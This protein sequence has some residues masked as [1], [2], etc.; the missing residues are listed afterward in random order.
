MTKTLLFQY[1]I[2]QD[3]NC[4]RLHSK[5]SMSSL[6]YIL[7]S[8]SFM[9]EPPLYFLNLVFPTQILSLCHSSYLKWQI[10]LIL[11]TLCPRPGIDW[12]LPQHLSGFAPALP[13]S[14]WTTPR[15]DCS[16][17]EP[18]APVSTLLNSHGFFSYSSPGPSQW[19]PGL[20]SVQAHCGHWLGTKCLQI[21]N[22][23]LRLHV[24]SSHGFRCWY[25]G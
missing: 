18:R 14:G 17:T 23:V 10:F 19:D 12:P 2:C 25:L 20:S 15:M 3:I 4:I 24:A 5:A 9:P 6:G 16:D 11:P 8:G 7:R 13:S 1:N 22:F 21:G